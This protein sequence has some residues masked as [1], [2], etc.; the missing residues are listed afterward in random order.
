[1][2]LHVNENV[3]LSRRLQTTWRRTV[4]T[5]SD[6]LGINSW[7]RATTETNGGRASGYY[8]SPVV[9]RICDVIWLKLVNKYHSEQ[10]NIGP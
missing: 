10:E 3:Q 1:M 5:E 7:A 9:K 2:R 4:E 6:K 8:A